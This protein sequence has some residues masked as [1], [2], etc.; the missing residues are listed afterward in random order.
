MKK[1]VS[2][3]LVVLLC[4]ALA[5]TAFATEYNSY[6]VYDDA[7]LLT[8]T[9]EN[10]LADRLGTIS[11]TYNAQ[12]VI[13]TLASLD[14]TD[15]DA[16]LEYA[17]DTMGLGYGENHDGVLLLVCMEPRQ[18]RILSNG[19][20]GDAISSTDI[21]MLGDRFVPDLSDGNYATAFSIFADECEYYLNGYINGYPFDAGATLIACLIAGLVIGLIAVLIMKGQ[22]KSVRAQN[23]ANVYVKPGSMKLTVQNDLYLY[24]QITRTKKESNSSS[25]GS[26]GGSRSTGGGSF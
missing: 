19:F 5:T 14:G 23:Q 15:V 12:V 9:E 24:R 1:F 11:Q 17:Y 20:A 25:G 21:D 3:L 10:T 22:L 16:Y 2:L 13:I 4:A 6:F 7:D 8:D 18:W 26:S